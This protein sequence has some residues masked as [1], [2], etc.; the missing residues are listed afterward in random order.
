[1]SV[2]VAGELVYKMTGDPS[3]LNKAINSANQNVNSFGKNSS[4]V[5]SNVGGLLAKAGIAFGLL[6]IGKAAITGAAALEQQKVAFEVLTGSAEKAN[7]ILKEIQQ[8]ASVTPFEQKDLIEASKLMLNFGLSVESVMPSLRMLSD[9][10][11]GDANKLQS[12]TLAFSQVS[13]AG[14]LTGQ[15]L[16]QFVNA[17]FNPLAEISAITGKSMAQLKDEMSKGAITADQVAQAFKRATS[18]GGRFYQMNQKQSATF[19]GLIST[20][21]DNLNVALVG[22]GNEVLPSL[23][24][25]LV[26]ITNIMG[27]FQSESDS[28]STVTET[29][30]NVAFP[31]KGIL[32]Y[33]E[34]ILGFINSQI[35]GTKELNKE[36]KGQNEEVKKNTE[37][38]KPKYTQEQIDAWSRKKD[39][40]LSAIDTI[41]Q[42]FIETA[43]DETELLQHEHDKQQKNLDYY[44]KQGY[45]TR[46]QYNEAVIANEEITQRK[47]ADLEEQAK[48]ERIQ[49]IQQYSDLAINS[50]TNILSAFQSYIEATAEAD[51]ARLDAQMQKELEAAGVA[52]ETAVEKAQAAVDTAVASGDAEAEATA[53]KELKKAQIE[54]KYDKKK[55]QAEYDAAVQSWEIQRILSVAQGAQAVLNAYS[56]AAAIPIYGWT[57]APFAAGLAATAAA[58]QIAA[59]N[60]SKPQAPKFAEGGIIPGSSFAGDNVI[61]RVNSGEMVLNSAQQA[62]LFKMANGSGGQGGNIKIF[63]GD[64]MIYDRLYTASKNGELLIDTRA[65]ITR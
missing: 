9:V 53:R 26:L 19:N 25:G 46:A 4:S 47:I 6:E 22:L 8:F 24:E 50:F 42:R 20:I 39:A 48:L 3:G 5:F 61:A 38:Q 43:L 28:V 12:L 60:A 58:I 62:E 16:L 52:E 15:D 18:E 56:S 44:L 64:D 27:L 65:V 30:K 10:A 41:N 23:K 59:V 14:R 54:E 34:K 55:R 51:Q 57:I 33:N 17:G 11:A 37:E 13:S 49:K 63:I 35:K 29:L 2:I 21:K 45:I 36:I 31:L 1:M 40:A 32:T 7:A